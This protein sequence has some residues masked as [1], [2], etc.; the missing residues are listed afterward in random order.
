[1]ID[2]RRDINT[3]GGGYRETK[4]DGYYAERDVIVYPPTPPESR[5][6]LTPSYKTSHESPESY[7]DYIK[8]C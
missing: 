4:N 2:D 5:D 6:Y 3:E 1:M 8:N 7:V